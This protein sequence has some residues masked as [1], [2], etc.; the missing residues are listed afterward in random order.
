M[1]LIEGL[2]KGKHVSFEGKECL[3]GNNDYYCYSNN[4]LIFKYMLRPYW[5]FFFR[6]FLKNISPNVITFAGL[7]CALPFFVFCL[8]VDETLQTKPPSA[9]CLIGGILIFFYQTLNNFNIKEKEKINIITSV[10]QIFHRICDV[11]SVICII[12]GVGVAVGLS[13]RRLAHFTVVGMI[14]FSIG[15]WEEYYIYSRNLSFFNGPTEGIMFASIIIVI[16]GFFNTFSSLFK[17]L[18]YY[19]CIILGFVKFFFCIITV[20]YKVKQSRFRI[21]MSVF[22]ILWT[23][24]NMIFMIIVVFEIL[25]LSC[26]IS[27][28]ENLGLWMLAFIPAFAITI[29]EIGV[30][31]ICNQSFPFANGVVFADSLII[32]LF[33]FVYF[34]KNFNLLTKILVVLFVLNM[35][36]YFRFVSDTFQVF[37][38]KLEENVLFLFKEEANS[39][40][41]NKSQILNSV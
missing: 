34:Y 3:K 20:L 28:N 15:I 9:F 40:E 31:Q 41:N 19:G 23:P 21:L 6:F 1:S 39:D 22:T 7:L 14:S 16:S 10:Q 17:D 11:F 27:F 25:P 8:V 4:S 38:P 13:S 2:T 12:I 32:L 35:A 36:V 5:N 24:L 30:S 29:S 37:Y 18:I 33:F 26:E